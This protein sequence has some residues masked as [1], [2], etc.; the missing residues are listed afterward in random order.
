MSE[1]QDQA[2]PADGDAELVPIAA[3]TFAIY[4]T[5]D[6]GYCLVTDIPGQG[7]QHKVIPGSVVRLASGG[8]ALGKMFRRTFGGSG[9]LDE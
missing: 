4:A 8:G 2:A 1:D 3:G 6:G 5:P 9:G 7:I